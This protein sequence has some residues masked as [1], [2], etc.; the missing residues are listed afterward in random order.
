M[1]FLRTSYLTAIEM[2]ALIDTGVF[3]KYAVDQLP[4]SEDVEYI[5]IASGAN[6]SD[7][8]Y[9]TSLMERSLMCSDAASGEGSY[10]C[11]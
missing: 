2:K 4:A 9:G 7:T 5:N 8:P 3:S 11:C 10:G 1:M 6:D